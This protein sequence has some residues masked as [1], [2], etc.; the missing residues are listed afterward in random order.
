MITNIE[1]YE[2]KIRIF[3]DNGHEMLV[4]EETLKDFFSKLSSAYNSVGLK[5]IEDNDDCA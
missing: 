4:I 3:Y 1:I 2:D 5:K